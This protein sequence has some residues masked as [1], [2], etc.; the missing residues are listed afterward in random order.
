MI[1]GLLACLPDNPDGGTAV[2]NPTGMTAQ[3][4]APADLSLERAR[5][6]VAGIELADCAGGG[7]SLQIGGEVDLLGGTLVEVP[8]GRWCGLRVVFDGE[9]ALDGSAGATPLSVRL[10]VAEVALTTTDAEVDAGSWILEL[11]SPGW[12][13][14]ADIGSDGL[15]DPSSAEHA[16]VAAAFV[17]GSRV[18]VDD[19]DGLVSAAERAAALFTVADTEG[20]D[21]SGHTEAEGDS[22]TSGGDTGDEGDDRDSDEDSDSESERHADT[23]GSTTTED[24][25]KK[26]HFDTGGPGKSDEEHG[27]DPDTG[28]PGKSGDT[29]GPGKSDED[30][31]KSD[32]G[33]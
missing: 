29:G 24:T 4:A 27:V 3:T 16:T 6:P 26:P 28:A 11:G 1:L 14:T 22:S 13:S 7:R 9:V 19:G 2:G 18:V 30:H 23:E 31:G 25:G 8:E 17:A 15:L 12:L 20:E 33:A 32:T 5:A 21:G 10:Q